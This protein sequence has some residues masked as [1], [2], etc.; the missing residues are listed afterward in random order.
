M[1]WL[2]TPNG[3]ASQDAGGLA[4]GTGMSPKPSAGERRR[5]AQEI[6]RVGKHVRQRALVVWLL[7]ME[8]EHG[9]DVWWPAEE[10]PEGAAAATGEALRRRG[11]LEVRGDA[12]YKSQLGGSEREYR[13]TE[14]GAQIGVR[15]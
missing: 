6:T 1:A 4:R 9:R 11:L 8:R 7:S 14:L 15:L 2:D 12:G 3:S 5:R 10:F 13:L